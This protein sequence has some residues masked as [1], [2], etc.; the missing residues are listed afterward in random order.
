VNEQS[1]DHRSLQATYRIVAAGPAPVAIIEL[2]A[3]SDAALDRALVALEVGTLPVGGVALRNL[4]GVDRGVVSRPSSALVHLMPHGGVRIVS[5]LAA[6]LAAAGIREEPSP[7]PRLV[8]P[9]ASDEIEARALDVISRASSPLAVELLLDQPRR[10]RE[11]RAHES[12]RDTQRELILS[13]L[14]RPPLVVGIGATNIGKSTLLNAMAGASVAIVANEP[15]TTR[16][17]VGVLLDARGLV[18]RYLDTPGL[19]AAAREVPDVEQAAI[20]ASLE[21][22]RHADLLLLLT[23]SHAPAI[24][25]PGLD[26]IPTL[27]VGLR[28]DLGPPLTT[29]EVH[30]SRLHVEG[31]EGASV[32]LEAIRRRLLP[33]DVLSDP[34][35]WRF[36]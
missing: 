19:R 20:A 11:P 27:I 36:W 12:A 13:R 16:D 10:W 28:G 14:L 29:A 26:G 7:D 22:A 30:V 31:A 5:L 24:I 17:H 35:P 8:Y 6:A 23:D 3:T 9:E 33:D 34:R 2:M 25:P 18:V 4:C 21:A 32:V 1:G 15:G